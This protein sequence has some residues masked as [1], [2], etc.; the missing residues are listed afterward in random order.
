MIINLK[1]AEIHKA[2]A[3]FVGNQGIDLTNKTVEVKLTAG[4]TA[5]GFTA[6]IEISP[7]QA[8]EKVAAN[9]GDGTKASQPAIDSPFSFG[10][11]E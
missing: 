6:Q 9:G 10:G 1:E 4:R 11:E 3:E 2:L 8:Q 5:N 7:K